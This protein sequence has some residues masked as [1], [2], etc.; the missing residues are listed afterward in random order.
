MAK[1]NYMK[2]IPKVG[3]TVA[4]AV[5]M[6]VAL[7]TQVSAAELDETDLLNNDVQPVDGAESTNLPDADTMEPA[8]YNKAV[9]EANGEI[10]EENE[11]TV[12][13]NEQTQQENN[14]AAEENEELTNGEL[15]NPDLNLPDAPETPNTDGM[16]VEEHNEAI[17][18][19]ND[20][21]EGYNKDVDDYN[22]KV[23]NYNEQAGQ[24]DQQ[25]KEDYLNSAE[26]QQ[27]LAD[28]AAWEAQEKA[29]QDYLAN[30]ED[31]QNS[32][33]YQ[34]YLAEKADW[35]IKE[36]AYQDSIAAQEDFLNSQEYKDYLKEKAEWE[37][38]EKAYQDYLAN[39]EDYQ[40]SEAYQK[41]LAE[42]ADWEIKEKAYQD[43][44]AAQEEFLNSQEYQDYLKEKA[45]WEIKEKAYQDY[46]ANNE[47][48]QNSEAYQ[49]YLAEKADWEIKEKA[50][51][52]SI[53]AQEDFLNSQEYQDYLK[54]KADW[55][56]KEKAYQDYLAN[57]EDYQNSEA[58][59]KYLA[60]KAD[61]EIKEKA[62]QDSLKAVEDFPNSQEYKDYLKEKADWEAKEKAY[63]DYLAN[64]EDYQNSQEY[65]D[66][67]EDKTVYDQ[68]VEENEIFG[69][70][71]DYNEQVIQN[72]NN[73]DEMNKALESV[74]VGVVESVDDVGELN[75]NVKI[76]EDVL[77][78]L[79]SF[80]LLAEEQGNL[81]TEGTK[82]AN[83]AGKGADLGSDEYAAYLEAVT[84]YNKKVDAF[85]VKVAAYNAAV[86]AYNEAVD[87][88]NQNKPTDSSSSTGIGTA[89][90]NK[91]ADWG[92][93][94][95]QGETVGHID[96]K[97]NAAASKDVTYEDGKPSYSTSVAGYEVT[98]VYSSEAAAKEN[99]DVYGV[100]YQ[101]SSTNTTVNTQKMNPYGGYEF[102]AGNVNGIRLDMASGKISFYATLEGEDG[103]EDIT[104]N[105][106][107]N[108]VYADGSYYAVS[109]GGFLGDYRFGENKD[110][111][112]EIETIDGVQYYNISGHSVYVISALTC[113]GMTKYN[114]GYGYGRTTVLDPW[115]LDLVLNM[116]TMIEI[117]QSASAQKVG[118]L[119]Y[120][121]GKT[122]QAD[123]PDAPGTEPTPPV[124]QKPGDAPEIEF[125]TV[126]PNPGPAPG[127][128]V[129]QKPGDAPSIDIPGL[130]PEPGPAPGAPVVQKPGD[131]P[132]IDIPGLEPEPG[133]APGVPVVQEPGNAP[134]APT[135]PTP[136]HR[137]EP[138]GKLDY[139]HEKVEIVVPPAPQPDPGPGPG[140]NPDPQPVVIDDDGPVIIDDGAVPL[141]DVPKTGDATAVF[142][143]MS[144]FS[145]FGLAFLQMF[146]RKK[147]EEK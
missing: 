43:S 113:D 114:S 38:K 48:Y 75:K 117:H 12:G 124:V 105:L 35:E 115:G 72:N 106:D 9:E 77:T 138:V 1:K 6:T 101:E 110:Q 121:M 57:N 19:Y 34:K 85:N 93:I 42:K 135:A 104:V 145:G 5:A 30:N 26:Y 126:E 64:N 130:E 139:L 66:Y 122:A 24:Y 44:I 128:P 40:N 73:V 88:Y 118:Y 84:E 18:N 71:T 99:P 140:P 7:S 95:T 137:L 8:E 20:E 32:E 83:H 133:P 86:A 61:W 103:T 120:E 52:D 56:I 23:D 27:Y 41:Y 39:N 127:A 65:Q 102:H 92:N 62:Y 87:T 53:A 107:A 33:A 78:V 112:L 143:A 108:S 55:E 116:Q 2:Y 96:V 123:A 14:A 142:G 17:G 141:A 109:N 119:S 59:Q 11:E 81:A 68:L 129:V 74:D 97:Y 21:A 49:K 47:D 13:E 69:E 25:A 70:V 111:K 54:E 144:A 91:K 58:Y 50:Y 4:V 146:G 16:N 90:S 45:D 79:R 98:G 147:K 10:L 63:Q 22:N 131:A 89:T 37:I 125:P 51:Q 29:H 15:P 3:G 36:K 82:L 60:E 100:S 134:N 28:R 46:L 94:K 31:Y 67:L 76:G 132:S 136:V 80:D